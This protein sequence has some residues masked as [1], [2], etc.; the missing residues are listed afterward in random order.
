[1]NTLEFIE[2]ARLIHGDRYSYAQSIFVTTKK[3]IEIICKEHGVFGQIS[4]S[5]LK[6]MG[7]K[8]CSAIQRGIDQKAKTDK[9]LIDRFT[10]MHGSKYDYSNIVF[11]GM[12]NP[13]EII[14]REHGSFTQA[15]KHH[16]SGH[17]CRQCGIDIRSTAISSCSAINFETLANEVHGDRYDYSKTEYNK[18]QIKIDI[19]CNSHGYFKQ[20]PNKHLTGR[21]CP[22][23][24][25]ESVS[26]IK[27][28]TTQ[29]FI[30][31]AILIHGKKYGYDSVDYKGYGE[32][33]KIICKEH[34]QFNQPAGVHLMGSGCSSCN[35]G[36]SRGEDE[37]A[38]YIKSLG[39][40]VERGNK[41]IISPMQLDIIVHDKKIAI[42]YNG[43]YWHSE[44]SGRGRSYHKRKM[45]LTNDAG[46][47]LIM[48]RDDEWETRK[49][50]VKSL[51]AHA[52]G[53]TTQS[54]GGRSCEIRDIEAAEYKAFVEDNHLQGAIGATHRF[55]LYY[56]DK[57][58]SAVGI[59][60]KKDR[61]ELSRFVSKRGVVV[62][63]A[64]SKLVKHYG[65]PLY[66]YCDMRLFTGRGYLSAGFELLKETD[67]DY[68]YVHR[69][70]DIKSRHAFQKSKLASKLNVF[71]DSKTEQQ[72][73]WVNGWLRVWGCGHYLM[74]HA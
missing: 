27:T 63:G 72:N 20:T 34:G 64:L 30:D 73:M 68:I 57:L 39:F 60:E 16:A 37:L 36:S 29:E 58:V 59:T 62:H 32:A 51:L 5:H 28:L 35:A 17:G 66:S 46:Y 23:C 7:C 56:N 4:H 25:G 3:Q 44:L 21:G 24:G 74:Y 41:S 38:D 49:P 65:K 40:K 2:K 61:C 48:I 45:K 18:S 53:I 70:G 42:E 15:A 31:K 13:I 9:L 14:C 47:R 33:V 22:K 6:G 52:L 19:G 12:E 1:M 26:R 69:N 67:V 54:I 50:I 11:K 55:G 43:N 8:K 71:D 10:D